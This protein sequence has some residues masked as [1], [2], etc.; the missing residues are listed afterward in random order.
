MKEDFNKAMENLRK[1]ELNRNPGNKNFL[2]SNKKYRENHS[3]RI[4]QVEDR[5]LDLK[6][7][8]IL[9]KK[10]GELLDKRL[11]SCERN[12]QELRDPIKRPNVQI[13]G[14]K[15]GEEEQAKGYI[16]YPIK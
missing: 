16:I 15:E 13:M 14:I 5:I 12:T 4:E 3:N 10:I 7:K 11:K 9:K 8:Y 2:K 1:K 6:T